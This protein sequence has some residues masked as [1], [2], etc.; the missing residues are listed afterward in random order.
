MIAKDSDVKKYIDDTNLDVM[1]FGLGH[2]GLPTAALF[3]TNGLNV[4]GIDINPKNIDYINSGRSP[5]DEPGLNELVSR[6]VKKGNLKATTNAEEALK[7][8]NIIIIIVPTPK[9][10]SNNSEL[11]AVKSVCEKVSN[12]LKKDDLIIVESTVPPNTCQDIVIPILEKSGLK[13]GKDFG[14]AYTPER[15][16][17]NNTLYEM[18]H[19]ARVIGG[20]NQESTETA[21]ALYEKITEGKIIK[22]KDIKTAEMVKLMENT[23]RD[24]NIALANEFAIVCEALKIDAIEAI[25]A[26]NHHPRVNILTPGPGVGG[27]CLAIDPYFIV[28]M[29]EK[30]GVEAPL[31]QTARNVNEKM[32]AH[33]VQIIT[34]SLLEAG[35][36]VE[37][38]KVGLLGVAYKGNNGDARETPAKSII[39]ILLEKGAEVYAN[40]PHTPN[41]IIKSFGAT[42]E[43][44]EGIMKCDCVVLVTDHDEYKKIE[45]EMI[46]NGVLV[47]TRPVLEP[48]KFLENGV[49]FKGVG[50]INELKSMSEDLSKVT[51]NTIKKS[52]K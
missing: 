25:K 45:P 38:S 16:L 24:T 41:N 47:C 46:K 49:I 44:F 10:G 39:K 19:N 21:A 42:P 33:V 15:A 26:A 14:V 17:P 1:I 35:K 12:G 43:S 8:F 7:L 32:P 52:A 5:I 40:D 27:H 29:A 31:I 50:R 30:N 4:I 18:T 48:T 23:Y 13:A 3:A 36:P 34:E 11:S 2:I 51:H 20:I 6:T 22:V 9:D 28:E 37:G